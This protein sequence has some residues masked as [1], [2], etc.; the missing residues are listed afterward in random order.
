MLKLSNTNRGWVALAC[1]LWVVLLVAMIFIP[2]SR[3]NAQA[4]SATPTNSLQ[5]SIEELNP[6]G[7][8]LMGQ[9][10]DPSQIYDAEQYMGFTTLCPTEPPELLNSKL[11]ALHLSQDDLEMSADENASDDEKNTAYVALLKQDENAEPGLDKVDL[12]YVDICQAPATTAYPLQTPIIVGKQDGKW[13]MM[14]A[15]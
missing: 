6:S 2:M 8:A 5:D 1:A 10:L 11:E 7:D 15:Q 14:P 12:R 3:P 4:A 13:F 9:M